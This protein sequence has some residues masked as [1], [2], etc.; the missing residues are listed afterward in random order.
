MVHLGHRGQRP[1]VQW[2]GIAHHP[3]DCL[4]DR[5]A[6]PY[7]RLDRI[8]ER[9]S[10][11]SQILPVFSSNSTTLFGRL[12]AQRRPGDKLRQRAYQP[13]APLLEPLLGIIVEFAIPVARSHVLLGHLPLFR[14]HSLHAVSHFPQSVHP[15]LLPHQGTKIRLGISSVP[16]RGDKRLHLALVG[17]L[18]QS[19]LAD[20]EHLTSLANGQRSP[21]GLL[22]FLLSHIAYSPFVNPT[23]AGSAGRLCHSLLFIIY[24]IIFSW[25]Q[26][27]TDKTSRLYQRLQVFSRRIVSAKTPKLDCQLRS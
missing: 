20:T 4:D 11:S 19:G 27:L 17:P 1:L 8:S 14:H 18:A 9:Q 7:E 21:G 15:V 12:L 24:S 26:L 22:R 3:H 6:V 25:F 2:R 5:V 16:S 23:T 13:V 10:G